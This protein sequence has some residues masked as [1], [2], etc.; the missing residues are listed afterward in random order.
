MESGTGL[1]DP[2]GVGRVPPRFHLGSEQRHP[3]PDPGGEQRFPIPQA[4]G[5]HFRVPPGVGGRGDS[6]EAP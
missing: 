3:V 1:P 6:F 4:G 2:G 5:L